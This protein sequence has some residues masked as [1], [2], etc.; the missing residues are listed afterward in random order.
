MVYGKLVRDE[1]QIH[2]F[3]CNFTNALHMWFDELASAAV[4][5]GPA[6]TAVEQYD[7]RVLSVSIRATSFEPHTSSQTE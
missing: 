4:F 6:S 1:R 2:Q 3:V 5:D 7:Y